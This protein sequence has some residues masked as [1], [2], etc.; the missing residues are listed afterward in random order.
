MST[1]CCGHMYDVPCI[2]CDTDLITPHPTCCSPFNPGCPTLDTLPYPAPPTF[3]NLPAY[4][5]L[6]LSVSDADA[7]LYMFVLQVSSKLRTAEGQL[8]EMQGV[9]S[10]E[11]EAEQCLSGLLERMHRRVVGLVHAAPEVAA[12]DHKAK[13]LHI[14][15]RVNEM[16]ANYQEQVP[17]AVSPSVLYMLRCLLLPWR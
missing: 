14:A 9:I 3:G 4:Y 2:K 6:W 1:H 13:E 5:I 15:P 8:V 7:Y 16:F 10:T 11:A 17:S 12:G